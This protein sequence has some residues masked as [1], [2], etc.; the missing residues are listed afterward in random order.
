MSQEQRIAFYK[1][2]M[3]ILM[4]DPLS[5][6]VWLMLQR[7]FMGPAMMIA[8]GGEMEKWLSHFSLN[9]IRSSNLCKPN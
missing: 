3:N 9:G 7:K 1:E 5:I 2:Y 4:T 6:P 8:K